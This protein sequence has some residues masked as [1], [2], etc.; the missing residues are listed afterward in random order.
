MRILLPVEDS[1]FSQETIRSLISQF[2]TRGTEVRVL[3]IIEPFTAYLTPDM[4]PEIVID[5]AKIEIE[6]NKQSKALVASVAEK[7]R[8]AGF[9]ATES[10]A[11]GEAKH[12]ILDEA[13]NWP[14]DLIVMGSHGFKG[15]SR[16]LLGSTSEAV[17]RH[18]KC[19][20]LVVRVP[21]KSPK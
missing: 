13:E 7:L 3:H 5:S 11:M 4:V 14:A 17:A 8:G 6:R 15:L 19:S 21:T 16:F 1:P 10:V 2:Q 20:V 18:A 9:T 12:V